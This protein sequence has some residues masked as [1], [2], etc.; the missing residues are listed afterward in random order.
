[1]TQRTDAGSTFSSYTQP[2]PLPSE[3]R[4]DD[5]SGLSARIHRQVIGYVGLALP[6][7][8]LV[9]TWLRRDD[10]DQPWRS[11]DSISAYYYTGAVAAFVGLLV[12]LALFLLTYRGYRNKYQL[13]D[14]LAAIVAGVAALG[15]AMFPTRAPDGFTAAAWWTETTGVI[16]YGSAVVLFAMFAVFS[17]WLFRL[18]GSGGQPA[19]DKQRRNLVYLVCGIAIVASIA[20]AGVAGM[21]KRSILVPESI[22]LVAFAVS[23]L[24][25]GRVDRSIVDTARSIGS[26]VKRKT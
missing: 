11:H 24:V 14:R 22:A 25:K 15:V 8:L 16:H 3:D 21:N 12:A 26:K 13:S 17:L 6:V 7:L 10:P 1:M 5:L 23:W 4:A 9:I 20:W 2:S 18:T 19:A